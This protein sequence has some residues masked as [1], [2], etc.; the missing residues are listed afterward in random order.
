MYFKAKVLS[1]GGIN[2]LKHIGDLSIS[3]GHLLSDDTTALSL[4]RA[5]DKQDS[6]G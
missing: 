1:G 4:T 3:T 5:A 6:P 2:H